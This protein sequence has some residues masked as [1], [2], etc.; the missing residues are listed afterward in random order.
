MI[1]LRNIGISFGGTWLFQN[2]DWHI[3]PGS[4]I[5]LVG[6]NGAGKTTLLKIICGL[7]PTETG[8]V[9]SPKRTTFGYLPQEGVEHRGRTLFDEAYSALKDIVTLHKQME[10]VQQEMSELDQDSPELNDLLKHLGH[11]EHRMQVLEGYTAE[12]RVHKVLKGLGF[13]K[14]ETLNPVESFSGGWQMRIT[15]A[16]LLLQEPDVLL[17]DEPTN[18]LDI[19]TLEWLETYLE[20]Y[21]GTVILVSHDR[22][23]LDQATNNTA[24]IE[25]GILEIYHGNYSYYQQEK[26]SRRDRLASEQ[27]R[28]EKER[29]RIERFVERFR[30]KN[31]KAKAVQSRIKMLEK[32]KTIQLPKHM[33]TIRFQFPEAP[34]SGRIVF[35]AENIG[36][37]YGEKQVFQELD[38]ILERGRRVALVGPNGAGKSTF[39]RIVCG[40]ESPT[41]GTFR[42]GHNVI[43]DNFSQDIHHELNPKNTV[44]QEVESHAATSQIP[45]LRNLLGAFLFSGDDVHKKVSVLSGGEKS[46]LALAKILLNPSNFLVLDEPTNHLDRPGRDVLL[47]ALNQYNGTILIVSHDRYF[48]DG[49]VD[50]IWEMKNQTLRRYP[51]NYS[52]Y[53]RIRM[54]EQE[55]LLAQQ[56]AQQA[57]VLE[58][59]ADETTKVSVKKTKEQKREEAEERQQKYQKR[60]KID[61]KLKEI[62]SAIEQRETRKA[63]LETLLSDTEVYHDG[64]KMRDIMKEYRDISAEL[65]ILYQEWEQ[66]EKNSATES[67]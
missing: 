3:P 67:P 39:C 43:L 33:K 11:L 19:P 49:L 56:L 4:R 42:M 58:D 12:T 45:Q 44:L 24:E 25:R 8:Q 30:Y 59:K 9:L 15:L 50:E 22:Y 63:E 57:D 6:P 13:S 46:R 34:R 60:K 2:L 55:K 18:H 10:S 62:M 5:G 64:D 27:Y 26:E 65:P 29:E 54:E 38:L 61:A 35:Q 53:H 51:G 31:T 23:F 37:S 1:Q 16:K 21:D 7:L 40:Q 66:I 48:L 32:M 14:S 28:L 52:Y 47:N 17:L 41:Q 20:D 36:K